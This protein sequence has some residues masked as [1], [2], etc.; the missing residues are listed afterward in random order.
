NVTDIDDPL[1]E[2]ATQ[3][4]LDWQELAAREIELFRQDMTALRVIPPDHYVGAVEAIPRIVTD[5]EE[6]RAR[7]AVYD[8]DGDLYLSVGLDPQFGTVSNLPRDQMRALFATRGGDPDRTGKQD[9]LD[10]LLW[11]RQRPGEP[12]WDTSL[13]TGRPGWHVEGT[14]IALD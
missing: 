6:L 8:V 10:T 2:R 3:R 11:Q 4:G 14:A 12:G 7:G 9:P 5:I 1:L 13:G